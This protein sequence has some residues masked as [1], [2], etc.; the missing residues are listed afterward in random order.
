MTFKEALSKIE[1]SQPPSYGRGNHKYSSVW[2]P[3]EKVPSKTFRVHLTTR[4]L[5]QVWKLCRDWLTS[6]HN[7][8]LD[9]LKLGCTLPNLANIFLHESITANFYSSKQRDQNLL[10]KIR[11]PLVGGPSL[12]FPKNCSGRDPDS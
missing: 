11:E 9:I 12:F 10:D 7:K 5:L 2:E 4:T 8:I 6:E 3:G 1:T